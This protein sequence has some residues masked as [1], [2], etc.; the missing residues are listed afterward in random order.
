M[1]KTIGFHR[2]NYTQRIKQTQ[3]NTTIMIIRNRRSK[4]ISEL[5]YHSI[6]R[7]HKES[8]ARVRER[9][10]KFEPFWRPFKKIKTRVVRNQPLKKCVKIDPRDKHEHPTAATTTILSEQTFAKTSHF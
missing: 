5:K 7:V 2:Q 8:G 3:T 10:K 4:K 9:E 1:A 6:I